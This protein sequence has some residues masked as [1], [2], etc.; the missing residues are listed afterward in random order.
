MEE[1]KHSEDEV[2][3][4]IDPEHIWV[5]DKLILSRKLGYS[6]GPTGMDVPKPNWYIV[7]PCIN[8]MGLGLGAE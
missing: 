7:R 2:W 5:M 6:C 4:T 8:A 3:N 1:Y